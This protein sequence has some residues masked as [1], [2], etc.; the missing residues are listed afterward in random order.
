MITFEFIGHLIR[1]SGSVL[2]QNLSADVTPEAVREN[3]SKIT[4]MTLARR[5]DT[6]QVSEF[7]YILNKILLLI[8][9][10]VCV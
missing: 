4:D 8:C 9:G 2:R 3:W 1:S 5:L 6:V 7:K 10:C